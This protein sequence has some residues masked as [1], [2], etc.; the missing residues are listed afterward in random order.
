[1]VSWTQGHGQNIMGQEMCDK[2]KYACQQ[3]TETEKA[4]G[5]EQTPRK[6]FQVNYI[7]DARPTQHL[8]YSKPVSWSHQL[9]PH[10]FHISGFEGTP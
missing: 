10:V 5:K 2:G 9:Q 1:M 4:Q 7:F 6:V 3:G 8:I